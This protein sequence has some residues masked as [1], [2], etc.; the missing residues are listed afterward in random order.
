MRVTMDEA[1]AAALAVLRQRLPPAEVAPIWATMAALNFREI[2]HGY[3]NPDR[4]VA[5]V[6]SLWNGSPY[7]ITKRATH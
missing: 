5:D 6:N 2:I 4:F 3:P 1:R 7:Q